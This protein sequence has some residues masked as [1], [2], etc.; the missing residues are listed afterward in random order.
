MKKIAIALSLF[1]G[2][3]M[4]VLANWQGDAKKAGVDTFD[5]FI[6]MDSF[7]IGKTSIIDY[8]TTAT[9]YTVK[10]RESGTVFTCSEL[11]NDPQQFNLPD[12]VKG[13]IYTFVDLD[14]TAAADIVI[15]PQ[16]GDKIGTGGAGVSLDIT[17]D[18][19]GETV[20]L[21][22]VSD[23]QWVIIGYRGTVGTGS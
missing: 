16:D 4:I 17:G 8:V 22:A 14:A 19:V 23:T 13:L 15:N 6:R 20:T 12:A 2:L 5:G 18:A 3:T 21:L 1:L 7:G 11:S 9:A 10:A